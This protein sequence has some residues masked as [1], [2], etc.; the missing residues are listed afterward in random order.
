MTPSFLEKVFFLMV[1]VL[2]GLG[3][4]QLVETQQLGNAVARIDQRLTD[5][6][7][8]TTEKILTVPASAQ[9]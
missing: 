7:Q 8:L 6:I 5:Y 3:A 1:S 4:W 9:K 2:I